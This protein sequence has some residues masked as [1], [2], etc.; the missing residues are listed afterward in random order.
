MI[1]ILGSIFRKKGGYLVKKLIRRLIEAGSSHESLFYRRTHPDP[2]K[3]P[4]DIRD[5]IV[6]LKRE[7]KGE[8]SCYYCWR[9]SRRF[10]MEP[11]GN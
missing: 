6:A 11:L 9:L 5:K 1:P 4:E 7:N 10:E 3:L 2:N 8:Y